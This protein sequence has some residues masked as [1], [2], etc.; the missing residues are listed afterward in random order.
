MDTLS[1]DTIMRLAEPASDPQVSIYLP[2]QRF[3]P[4][5]QEGDSIRFKNLLREARTALEAQ[6]VR[7]AEA[8]QM[9]APAEALLD[10]R[11][12][13][14]RSRDGLAVFIGKDTREVFQLD[15][16]VPK[17]VRV[18]HRFWVRPLL[19]L[20][21]RNESYWLL[22]LSQNRV[23]LFKGDRSSFVEVPAE[24]IPI[25]LSAAFEWKDLEKDSLQFHTGTSSTGGHGRRAAVFHGT[26][27][28][29]A[30]KEI[31]RFLREI[32]RGLHEYLGRDHAPLVLAGVDFLIPYYHEISDCSMLLADAVSGNP[33][34]LGDQALH[35]LSWPIAK[36]AFAQ[37]GAGTLETTEEAWTS[38]LV[39]TDPQSVL[40][41]AAAGRVASLLLSEAAGWW[42]KPADGAAVAVHTGNPTDDEDLLETAALDTLTKGGE[43]LSFP[44]ERMPHGEPVV[45]LLR[46]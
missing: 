21:G 20:L 43:V 46:Y 17:H 11:Q 30:K 44:A 18:G 31:I 38:P 25:S 7:A 5:S 35:E 19:P 9:L 45:A 27:E 41:A 8:R 23:R 26:G 16:P 2:T 10:D 15:I 32:D 1:L 42:S 37:A 3:G 34:A 33:D 29:D 39:A 6:G 36:A 28:V 40:E 4:D 12:L 13:W 22:A 14:L 24:E